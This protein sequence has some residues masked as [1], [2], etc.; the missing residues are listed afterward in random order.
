MRSKIAEKQ[1]AA[2]PTTAQKNLE[3]RKSYRDSASASNVKLQIGKILLYLQ[4]PLKQE[5]RRNCWALFEAKL[6]QYY[7]LK[8]RILQD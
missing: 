6:C 8:G 1:K 3:R 7:D 2:A 5:E 4:T